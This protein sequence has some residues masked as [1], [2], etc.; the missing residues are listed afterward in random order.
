MKFLSLATIVFF[1]PALFAKSYIVKIE[2]SV[3]VS[4]VDFERLNLSVNSKIPQLNLLVLESKKDQKEILEKLEQVPGVNYA[5]PDY[6]VRLVAEPNDKRWKR[7]Y[8]HEAIGSAEAWEMAGE[9]RSVIVAVTD[10]GIQQNR[11][12]S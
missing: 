7:Q 11:A 1:G 2:P 5:E 6:E 9:Q 10:T 3:N 12:H 8:H 4:A